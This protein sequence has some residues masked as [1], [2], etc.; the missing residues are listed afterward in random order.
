MSK[1]RVF[2]IESDQFPSR[3]CFVET[4]RQLE[5][6]L[7][8]M[9]ADDDEVIPDLPDDLRVVITLTEIDK[10]VLDSLEPW[11]PY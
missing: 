11:E 8:C 2:K 3:P 4:L 5:D 1:V 10:D 7:T 6:A 9:I